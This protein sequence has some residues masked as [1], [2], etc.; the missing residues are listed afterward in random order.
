MKAHRLSANAVTLLAVALLVLLA[1]AARILLRPSSTNGMTVNVYIDNELYRTLDL[2]EQ[3]AAQYRIETEGSGY[4]VLE[5]DS[6]GVS[7]IDANCPHKSCVDQG[8]VDAKNRESRALGRW[9]L[10]LPHRLSVE[11]V[12]DE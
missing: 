4:N 12:S 6:G 1:F 9:I 7:M 5:L 2:P 10:C 8:R 3:G 11:L